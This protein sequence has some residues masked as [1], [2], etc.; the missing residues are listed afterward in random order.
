MDGLSGYLEDIFYQTED[1]SSSSSGC[2][3]PTGK[4]QVFALNTCGSCWDID[5]PEPLWMKITMNFM[6]PD[7][8][9]IFIHAFMDTSCQDYLGTAS[10]GMIPSNECINSNEEINHLSLALE[11]STVNDTGLFLGLYDNQ[12]NCEVNNPQK[13]LLQGIYLSSKKNPCFSGLLS[14]DI[15]FHACDNEGALVGSV[16]ASLDGSCTGRVIDRFR[17][18]KE[19]LKEACGLGLVSL[20]NFGYAGYFNFQCE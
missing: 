1:S 12:G 17:M 10:L 5:I 16:Y 4:K 19:T 2:S 9:G 18:K 7:R 20:G 3:I 15:G 8:Y 11:P 13:G 14:Q 6:R